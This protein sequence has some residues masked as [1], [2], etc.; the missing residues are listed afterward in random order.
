MS[1]WKS[2]MK[3]MD[4]SGPP[5]GSNKRRKVENNNNNNHVNEPCAFFDQYRH[6]YYRVKGQLMYRFPDGSVHPATGVDEFGPFPDAPF[7][8]NTWRK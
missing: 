3:K 5:L 7:I 1:D 2:L 4:G 6:G 8:T